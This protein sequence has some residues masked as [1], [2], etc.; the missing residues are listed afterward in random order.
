MDIFEDYKLHAH[1][2]LSINYPNQVYN[3]PRYYQD[4]SK[5]PTRTEWN[6][7]NKI[8]K[9]ERNK[10]YEIVNELYW[11]CLCRV[12]RRGPWTVTCTLCEERVRRRECLT[13]ECSPSPL[14][15]PTCTPYT[16]DWH[17]ST[18]RRAGSVQY[19]LL[20]LLMLGGSHDRSI[21]CPNFMPTNQSW[22]FEN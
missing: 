4:K 3:L 20:L 2:L 15:P 1:K 13:R 6:N 21:K 8:S 12:A 22:V 9:T 18:S 16:S 19:S 10:M 17:P 5:S 7:W 14:P 11:C